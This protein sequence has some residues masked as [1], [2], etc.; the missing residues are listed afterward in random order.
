MSTRSPTWMAASRA[1]PWPGPWRAPPGHGRGVL[2]DRPLRHAGNRD[3]AGPSRAAARPGSPP[4]G[5][6]LKRRR[7]WEGGLREDGTPL[8]TTVPFIERWGWLDRLWHGGGSLA[9]QKRRRGAG[10]ASCGGT[11]VQLVH[12]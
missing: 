5:V 9:S 10:W 11:G 1:G 7:A 4:A 2:I 3:Q 8:D 12:M 6:E